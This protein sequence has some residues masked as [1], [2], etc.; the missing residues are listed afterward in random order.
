MSSYYEAAKENCSDIPSI[1]CEMDRINDEILELIAE[2][3][4][5]VKRAGDLKS[6]TTKVADDRQ[7]VADQKKKIIEKSIALEVPLE[8]SLPVFRELMESS[9]KFKQEYINRQ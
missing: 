6:K 7:R 8:I 5:Y 3:T 4:A 1:R 9:I 2:R